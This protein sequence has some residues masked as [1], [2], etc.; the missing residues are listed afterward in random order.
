MHRRSS[1]VR[2]AQGLRSRPLRRYP[3]PETRALTSPL[4]DHLQ[5]TIARI[6]PLDELAMAEV[7]RH[8]DELT[9]PPGSLGR[10]ERL[11]IQLAGITRSTRPHFEHPVIT[12]LAADHGVS[13]EH[14]SAYPSEVTAQM[15]SNFVNGGAAINVLAR[16]AGARVAVVDIGVDADLP[17]D[18][19]IIHRKLAHAT[20]NM[21]QGPAMSVDQAQAAI[22]VGLEVVAAECA[23]GADLVALGE[24]GIANT[25][26]ASAMVAAL[27]GAPVEAVT[28]RGTGIDDATWRHKI[29]VIE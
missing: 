23:R 28:G 12:V 20:A 26:A 25:T 17:A 7:R 19:P 8:Q 9:K 16:Q 2:V 29:E 24:M 1:P 15:V 21:A 3:R 4:P 5:E 22:G 13:V 18:L 10:L 6:K 14:V 27:T 11:S